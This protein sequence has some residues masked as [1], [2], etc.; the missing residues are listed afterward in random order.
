MNTI[1]KITLIQDVMNLPKGTLE[2]ICT[3]LNLDSTGYKGE[4]AT[5]IFAYLKQN[6]DVQEEILQKYSNKV[7]AGKTS[8]SWFRLDDG[9][10]VSKFKDLIKKNYSSDLFDSLIIPTITEITTDPQLIGAAEGF[11]STE[12]FLRLM[13]KSGIIQEPYG[14]EIRTTPRT[15]LA[16]VYYDE[17]TGVLE[18]R[19]DSRKAEAFAKVIAKSLSQQV[20]LEQV[21]APFEQRIG[22]IADKLDGELIDTNSTPEMILEN[23]EEEQTQAVANVL[24]ALDDYFATNDTEQLAQQLQEANTAFGNQKISLPFSALILLGMD[25]VGLGGESE[26]RGLPLYD[27]LNPNLQEQGGYIR[28]NFYDDGIEKSYTIR[29]GMKSRSIYFTTPAT[30]NVIAYVRE[31]VII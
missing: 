13:Y 9:L 7:F 20:N 24:K 30:E 6:T 15:S 5:R 26:I 4:L 2:E 29:V 21:K 19:G 17:N 23:F 10:S 14:T 3:D 1:A 22:D 27:Y 18:I 11:T 8:L 12:I 31:K 28:F 16:T 25:R